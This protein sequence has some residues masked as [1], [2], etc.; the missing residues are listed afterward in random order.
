MKRYIKSAI[1]SISDADIYTKISA[2]ADPDT[3]PEILK[4]LSSDSNTL[5]RYLVSVNPNTPEGTTTKISS[6]ENVESDVTLELAV[7]FWMYS[8]TTAAELNNLSG[9]VSDVIK[10]C[11]YT[12]GNCEI[13]EQNED[14]EDE[15][16]DIKYMTMVA[17]FSGFD[18][19]KHLLTDFVQK[20]VISVFRDNGYEV[21][22][23]EYF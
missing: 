17:E 23:S 18:D 6:L 2:A 11:G 4:E 7:D 19:D 9:C 10:S 14:E 22:Y 13:F 15:G 3:P 8:D 20:A 16:S 1:Q 21:S 5:V 12:V